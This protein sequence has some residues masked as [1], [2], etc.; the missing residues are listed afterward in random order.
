MSVSSDV[1]HVCFEAAESEK[2]ENES[3]VILLWN[4]YEVHVH[5]PVLSSLSSCEGFQGV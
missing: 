2:E 5:P 4:N 3:L 1:S